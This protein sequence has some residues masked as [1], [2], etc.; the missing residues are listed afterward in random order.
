MQHWDYGITEDYGDSA[1]NAMFERLSIECTVTVILLR[2][3]LN[4]SS[5]AT[6]TLNCLAPIE[7]E[8]ASLA[9]VSRFGSLSIVF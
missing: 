1:L 6:A 2:S 8:T 9:C 5:G 7:A 4:S 3:A